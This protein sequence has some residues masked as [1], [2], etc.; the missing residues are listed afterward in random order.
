MSTAY[1]V[2][3]NRLLHEG[4]LPR[5]RCYNPG[6]LSLFPEL[7]F[8]SLFAPFIFRVTLAILFGLASW[9]RFKKGLF[10]LSIAEALV[11]ILLFIGAWTQL[12]ALGA[13]VL[14][15]I[16]LYSQSLA[17]YTRSTLLLALPIAFSL[18]ITGAGAFAFDLPL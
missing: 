16:Y 18:L 13:L 7:L 10:V 9:V 17:P 3:Q 14:L 15:G 6:M 12:A 1:V 8:L 5:G 11:A 2:Q 4:T